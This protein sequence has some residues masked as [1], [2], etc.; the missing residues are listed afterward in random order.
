MDFHDFK[1]IAEPVAAIGRG[2]ASLAAV[3]GYRDSRH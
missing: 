1:D 3:F 2:I